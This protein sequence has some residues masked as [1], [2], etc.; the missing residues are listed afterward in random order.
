MSEER[1]VRREEQVEEETTV[2][3]A[4]QVTRETHTTETRE[5]APAAPRVTNVNAT[6][7]STTDPASGNVS[8]NTP[9]GTQVNINT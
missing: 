9:D 1:V 4:E 5:V 8:I 7:T 2:A 6:T 3:P